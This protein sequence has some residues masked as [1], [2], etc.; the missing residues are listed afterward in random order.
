[1][2]TSARQPSLA[3][4][5][6]NYNT[7]PIAQRCVEACF[8]QDRGH[9]DSIHVYDDCS[10]VEFTGAFP[11]G[12]QLHQGSVNLGLTRALNA[13]FALLSEDIVVLF[14]S[15]AY[16]TTAF[17]DEARAMFAQDPDLG[18]VAFKTIGSGGRATQ[19]WSSEAN[20]WSLLLGQA[21]YAKLE[22]W[23]ADKSGRIAVFTCAMAV[24]KT[25]FDEL[26]GFDEAFDWLDLDFDFGMRMNRSRWKVAVVPNA[27]V[28]HEGG[29]AAQLTRKRVARYYKNRWYLL[30]KF[31]RIPMKPLIKW[32]IIARLAVE[33]AILLAAGWLLFPNPAIR[34]DK[35]TGRRELIRLC[36]ET[37]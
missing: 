4:L 6:T 12:T 3:I 7:W 21:L 17:C 1:M 20:V 24:R 27:R 26:H 5:L 10:S 36:V 34:H 29:G 37:F 19:S 13:A 8:A 22:P 15:D 18:L 31:R 23:L 14:D 30:S 9:F 11:A 28:F 33:Y 25:A 35:V 16:P 2:P 32:L